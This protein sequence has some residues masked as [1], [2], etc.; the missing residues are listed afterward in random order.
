M[1]LRAAAAEEEERGESGGGEKERARLEP[2]LQPAWGRDTLRR[3]GLGQEMR[4]TDF[5]TPAVPSSFLF[6]FYPAFLPVEHD[7][8]VEA[9]NSLIPPPLPL[10]KDP[11][12]SFSLSPPPPTRVDAAA[13]KVSKRILYTEGEAR[14]R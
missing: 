4:S 1:R 8:K 6:R 5:F 14:T 12:S 9:K 13:R 11:S 10:N 7:K 2:R 3:G